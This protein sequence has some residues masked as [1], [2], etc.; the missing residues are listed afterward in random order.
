MRLEAEGRAGLRPLV[1]EASRLQTGVLFERPLDGDG[2]TPRF[3][4]G[5][6][7]EDDERGE[8]TRTEVMAGFAYVRDRLR[9]DGATYYWPAGSG[10]AEAA[11]TGRRSH[12]SGARLTAQYTA[13]PDDRGLAVSVGSAGGFGAGCAGVGNRRGDRQRLLARA[14]PGRLRLRG[15]SWPV[16]APTEKFCLTVTSSA[17]ARGSATTSGPFPSTSFGEHWLWRGA[18]A[19]ASR[20]PLPPGFLTANREASARFDADRGRA[21]A[22]QTRG[23]ELRLIPGRAASS[24][25]EH[26]SGQAHRAD[27]RSVRS[28]ARPPP[29]CSPL[30][31][32]RTTRRRAPRNRG[33]EELTGRDAGIGRARHHCDPR[34]TPSPAPGAR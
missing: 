5:V 19:R 24:H 22:R 3:G 6:R 32:Y 26:R 34:R 12:D 9:V 29:R 14:S 23:A 10:E 27:P 17:C 18:G 1:G 2:W 15:G 20:R 21:P 8:A 28:R 25:S 11:G 7:H 16:D 30:E 33:V 13:A 31:P 4:F